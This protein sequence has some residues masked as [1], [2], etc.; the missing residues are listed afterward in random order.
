MMIFDFRNGTVMMLCPLILAPKLIACIVWF[1]KWNE[2]VHR[3]ITSIA[4]KQLVQLG[5]MVLELR[6]IIFHLL[7]MKYN[8][9]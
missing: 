7:R 5:I 9:P 6:T 3:R 8:H 1:D 2:V 4:N